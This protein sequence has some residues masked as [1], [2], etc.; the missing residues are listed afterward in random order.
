MT[1]FVKGAMCFAKLIN[2]YN[3]FPSFRDSKH[4]HVRGEEDFEGVILNCV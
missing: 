4:L 2:M 1:K 3:E